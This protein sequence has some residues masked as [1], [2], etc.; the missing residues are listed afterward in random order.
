MQSGVL[1]IRFAGIMND[2]GLRSRC[3]TACFWW[4][5]VTGRLFYQ[6]EASTGHRLFYQATGI[7]FNRF[8]A[9]SPFNRIGF[10]FHCR[11][12]SPVYRLVNDSTA[13]LNLAHEIGRNNQYH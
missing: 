10:P 11:A 2:K 6:N 4:Q 13:C 5:A 7:P 9:S 8:H 3:T 12:D 1:G